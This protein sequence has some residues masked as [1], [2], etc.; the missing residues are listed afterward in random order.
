[1][2]LSTIEMTRDE[3]ELHLLEWADAH[4][5]LEDDAIA[6]GYKQ[7]AKGHRLIAL[8]ETI[9]A[10]GE[11]E[12][13]RPRLA[14]APTKADV[15]YLNRRRDGS[16]RFTTSDMPRPTTRRVSDR[17][18]AVSVVLPPIEYSD[19]EKLHRWDGACYY[20]AMVPVVPPRFRS[21]GWKSSHV[22]FEAEWAKHTP[23]APVDPAL[24]RHLMGDL[25]I[26]R[27]VWDLTDLERAVLM[28]RNR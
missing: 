2:D 21:A 19:F 26:V 11:D 17:S 14:V 25:W 9:R 5:T 22:L 1:M 16:V 15:I 6:E 20:Q 13:H 4:G 3:A 18:V 28:E 24:I 23:P 27:G 8:S 10:G 7:L 12:L